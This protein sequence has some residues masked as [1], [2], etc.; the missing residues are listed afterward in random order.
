M[1]MD[2][3]LITDAKPQ[4]QRWLSGI[5]CGVTWTLGCPPLGPQFE[6]FKRIKALR[7]S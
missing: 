2:I 6:S 7:A 1:E 5:S 4:H 3:L